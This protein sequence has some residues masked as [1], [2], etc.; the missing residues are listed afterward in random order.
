MKFH[1]EPDLGFRRQMFKVEGTE[2]QVRLLQ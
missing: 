2:A 1:V